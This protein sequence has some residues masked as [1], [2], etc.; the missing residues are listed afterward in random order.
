M[1]DRSERAVAIVGIGAI[2]PDAPSARAFRDNVWAKKYSIT[3]VP[4]DRW[5]V[6]DYYDPDP[7][8]PAKTYS[9]IGAW[10]R[11][12]QFDWKRWHIPPRVAGAMDEGQQWAITIAA[13]ALADYGYPGKP[14][15]T[16]RTAVVLGNAMAGERHYLTTLR[17]SFPEYRAPARRGEGVPR[18]P[19]RGAQRHPLALERGRHEAD[20]RDH[21][22]HDAGGA[23]EHPLRPGGQR[24]QPAR[25]E[26]HG[27]RR[28]RLD[29]RRPRRRGGHAGGGPLRRR[30][31]GRRRPQHGHE[32]VREVL[33]DRRAL[34]D[35]DPALRRRGGRLR[36]GRGLGRLPAEAP[37]RRGERR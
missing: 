32:L 17:I 15:D 36:D 23:V 30:D 8:A 3:E 21:R 12:F 33:E 5:S 31:H 24:P 34:R 19:G 9:K 6:A 1:S 26:L 10:V 2:L 37:R 7:T 22:G 13:E 18:P 4:P 14:L 16:E 29:L 20:A 27:R 28:L 35:G 25:A 11:G